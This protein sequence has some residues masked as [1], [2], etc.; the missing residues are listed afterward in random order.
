MPIFIRREKQTSCLLDIISCMFGGD[1][2][3]QS[4][5][6]VSPQTV[7]QTITPFFIFSL[8][9]WFL[10]IAEVET[11]FLV[12]TSITV[13]DLSHL[14]LNSWIHNLQ[15]IWSL[16]FQKFAVVKLPL[17]WSAGRGIS[18]SFLKPRPQ[19]EAF[20]IHSIT[21]PAGRSVLYT[22]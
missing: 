16:K 9:I 11:C 10:R 5:G 7:L 21:L 6:P 1:T 15:A 4:D 14:H 19:P 18:Q 20:K 12:N 22:K 3:A 17:Y 13:K 2:P 8:L